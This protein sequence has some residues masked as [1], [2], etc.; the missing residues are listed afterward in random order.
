MF[1]TAEDFVEPLRHV[2]AQIRD[3]VVATCEAQ[4]VEQVAAVADDALGGDTIYAIDRVS[5][6]CLIDL[7]TEHIAVVEPIV[8]AAEGLGGHGEVV[9]PNGALREDARWKLI[10]DP[11]DGTRGLMYQ[12]RPGW[13]LSAVA[14]LGDGNP[15]LSDVT[16]AVMTEIPLLKQH[17]CDQL[18]A[19]RGHGL[20]AQRINRLDGSGQ[21]LTPRPSQATSIAHGFATVS[22]FFPGAREVL[23]ALDDSIAEQVL[24]PVEAGKA[25]YF[26]D[27]YISS[28]G[29]LYELVMGH[30][31]FI[32][33]LRP[34]IEPIAA[35]HGRNLGI[36]AHPYDLCTALIAEEAGVIITSPTGDPLDAALDIHSDVGW[37][38]YANEQIRAQ[39]EPIL[40]AELAKWRF[41]DTMPDQQRE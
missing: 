3:A 6:Q 27:Q 2:Q 5:E 28:G 31:R 23:A 8:L 32:A 24:G 25:Q 26:E 17:L 33:D 30:D 14:P 22:R 34:L 15:H 4:A 7:V 18:W 11:I 37:I 36:C 1:T 21:D 13:I 35:A 9:L 41:H 38:G 40:Q 39:V 19:V 10:V 12:K 16:V 20:R 29:Q